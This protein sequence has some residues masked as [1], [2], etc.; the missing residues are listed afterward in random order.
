MER[1]ISHT[2]DL[3]WKT[4]HQGQYLF[5]KKECM[6]ELLPVV[7]NIMNTSLSSYT[8]LDELKDIM[9]PP[10]MNILLDLE[11]YKHFHSISGVL[12]LSISLTEMC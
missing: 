6:G 12:I 8:M 2:G 7:T 1:W 3:S 10:L 9:L 11:I 4:T 5:V